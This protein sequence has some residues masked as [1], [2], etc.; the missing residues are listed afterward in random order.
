LENELKSLKNAGKSDPIQISLALQ[1]DIS[2]V[3]LSE[4][5]G[6]SS[7]MSLDLTWAIYSATTTA[8]EPVMP[9]CSSVEHTLEVRHANNNIPQTA[10]SNYDESTPSGNEEPMSLDLRENDMAGNGSG[11]ANHVD[12]ESSG[13]NVDLDM[14]SHEKRESKFIALIMAS[15]KDAAKR[16]SQVFD[17]AL[18]TGIQQFDIWGSDRRLLC[19]KNDVHVREQ[20]ALQKHQLKFKERVLTLK[21][22]VFHH[23]WREDLRLLSVRKQRPKSQK[24]I[25][26]SSLSSQS[27]TQK[28]RSS[29]R[30]RFTLPG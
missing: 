27:S 8:E 28:H 26:L 10:S 21:F 20:L 2:S 3:P 15:N 5:V 22:R 18:A 14:S 29:L 12:G 23:L 13:A 6:V 17:G 7:K 4:S 19:R 1:A 30:S 11:N 9:I 25:E 24:R 16:A